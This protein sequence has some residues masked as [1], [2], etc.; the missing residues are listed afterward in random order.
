LTG[1]DNLFALTTA[2]YHAQPLMIQG[3]GAGPD[4]TAQA[5]LAD[6]LALRERIPAP[7]AMAV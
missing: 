3:A 6:V 5:L 4:V 2:R 7:L 1:C